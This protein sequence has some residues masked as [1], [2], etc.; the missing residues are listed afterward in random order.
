MPAILP[1]AKGHVVPLFASPR[2]VR[3]ARIQEL[4][5]QRW[6]GRGAPGVFSATVLTK[7]ALQLAAMS[8]VT[9]LVGRFLGPESA[10][11]VRL[12]LGLGAVLVG[13][14]M[15][16]SLWATIGRHVREAWT[17]ASVVLC[18]AAIGLFATVVLAPRSVP[19]RVV[20]DGGA[21][22][23]EAARRQIASRERARRT[24]IS[25]AA[26]VGRNWRLITAGGAL[27]R[28]TRTEAEGWCRELGEGWSL[29]ALAPFPELDPWPRLPRP[30]YAWTTA[31]MAVSLGTGQRAGGYMSV[32]RRADETHIVLCV[33]GGLSVR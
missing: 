11:W 7:F 4:A 15:V 16:E 25:A 29:P 10:P 24:E 26:A 20:T 33:N 1:R 28:G 12:P 3:L 2:D 31:E 8:G 9:S 23:V 6:A 13:M 18:L 27:R 30:E 5:R 22:A 19:A 14:L 17:G 21:G 32:G